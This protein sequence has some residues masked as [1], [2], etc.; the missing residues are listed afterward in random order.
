MLYLHCGEV[1]MAV[2]LG[3]EPRQKPPKGFVLPLHHRTDEKKL[4][5]ILPTATRKIGIDTFWAVFLRI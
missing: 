2:R 4:P 1:G 5:S 3:F